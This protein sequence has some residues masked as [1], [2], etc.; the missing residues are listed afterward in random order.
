[1]RLLGSILFSLFILSI[2]SPAKDVPFLSGRVVDEARVLSSQTI[3]AIENKLRTHEQAKGNQ[4]AVLIV[5]SLEGEALESYSLKVAETWKL[6]QKGKYNGVLLL[7]AIEDRKLRI[8]VGYGLEGDLTDAKSNRII[9]NIITPEFRRSDYDNGI[10]NGV[11]AIVSVI[12]GSDLAEESGSEEEFEDFSTSEIIM[13]SVFVFSI[14]GLFTFFG[15]ISKGGAGWFLYFFLIPFYATFP[16][17]ILGFDVGLIILLVYLLGFLVVR[18]YL[19][20]TPKGKAF[21][22]SFENMQGSTTGHGGGVWMSSS[23]SGGWSSGGSTWS[24]G[25]GSF[26][27]GGSSGSW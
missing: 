17:V 3:S 23:R 16:A 10:L 20:H 19:H 13:L 24:G 5:K 18:I 7:I 6:G 1:M 27:G 8:E 21:I 4:V 2:S 15:L 26:G 12:E 11:N 25:G 14:L 22:K 9:R